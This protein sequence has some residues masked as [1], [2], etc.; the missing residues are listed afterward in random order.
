MYT[1][2]YSVSSYSLTISQAHSQAIMHT[3]V[4]GGGRESGRF[5]DTEYAIRHFDMLPKIEGEPT[6]F[7]KA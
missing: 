4:T 1:Y 7:L 5:E 6:E 2:I 3:Y